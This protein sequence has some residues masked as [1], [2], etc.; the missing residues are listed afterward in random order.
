MGFAVFTALSGLVIAPTALAFVGQLLRGGGPGEA[1]T[2][3]CPAHRVPDRQR[4]R[5]RYA[6]AHRGSG[7]RCPGRAPGQRRGVPAA[8]KVHDH[9]EEAVLSFPRQGPPPTW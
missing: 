9:D 1:R 8:D 5:R 3:E 7:R 2:S 6:V 4:P